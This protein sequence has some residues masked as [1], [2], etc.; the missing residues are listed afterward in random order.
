VDSE[1]T[2]TVEFAWPG[3][4]APLMRDREPDTFTVRFATPVVYARYK[5]ALPRGYD[6]YVE[7]VGFEEDA[8]GFAAGPAKGEDGR[9]VFLFE[10]VDLPEHE[11]LGMR[12][13]LKGQGDPS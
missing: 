9:P 13:Q 12:L 11:K 10:G 1:I 6:A 8:N 3:M 2:I 7:P 5:V 4:C